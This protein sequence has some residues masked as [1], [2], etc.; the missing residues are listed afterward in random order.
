MAAARELS[1]SRG[2]VSR[3]I[4]ELE[5]LMGVALF[6]RSAHDVR[7]TEMGREYAR[8]VAPAIREIARASME[9]RRNSR[10]R[11]SAL[12][13]QDPAARAGGNEHATT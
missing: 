12:T 3:T 2:A 9:V 4:K 6:V 1:I 5:Q 7:L 8:A 10:D 11:L 13:A